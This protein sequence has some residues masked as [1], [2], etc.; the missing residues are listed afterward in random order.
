MDDK[1]IKELEKKIDFLTKKYNDLLVKYTMMS[2]EMLKIKRALEQKV[3]N[4]E[5]IARRK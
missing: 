4:V 3:R 2:T 1:K 5:T